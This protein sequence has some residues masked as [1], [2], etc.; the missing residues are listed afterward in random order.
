M[1]KVMA[2]RDGKDVERILAV[3]QGYRPYGNAEIKN[4]RLLRI[5]VQDVD[6]VGDVLALMEHDST[7]D[8]TKGNPVSE[9]W[10]SYE[11]YTSYTMADAARTTTLLSCTFIELKKMLGV[12]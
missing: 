11:D 3:M 12:I 2:T 9:V 4:R 7:L 10:E 8:L 6:E 5:E 1:I